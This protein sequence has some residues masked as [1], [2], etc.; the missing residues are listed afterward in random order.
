MLDKLL[1]GD[2]WHYYIPE[3]QYYEYGACFDFIVSQEGEDD[4]IV[5]EEDADEDHVVDYDEKLD[6][7]QVK[8]RKRRN[9]V[10]MDSEDDDESFK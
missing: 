2:L 3:D 1:Y 5:D 10:L 9:H 6:M 8:D 4:F 7:K